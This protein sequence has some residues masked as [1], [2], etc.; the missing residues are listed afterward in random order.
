MPHVR[1]YT[2]HTERSLCININGHQINYAFFYSVFFFEFFDDWFR[3]RMHFCLDGSFV[4]LRLYTCEIWDKYVMV[5]VKWM[6]IIS[7]IKTRNAVSLRSIRFNVFLCVYAATVICTNYFMKHFFSSRFLKKTP[8]GRHVFVDGS[9]DFT[10]R[11]Y[12]RSGK[13]RWLK[14]F[15]LSNMTTFIYWLP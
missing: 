7:K 1:A 5:H 4:H 8:H 10:E 11:V 2:V 13:R 3:R 15:R 14:G 6:K 9:M 12:S